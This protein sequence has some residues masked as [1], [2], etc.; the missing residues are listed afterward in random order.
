MKRSL[1]I[2]LGLA[3]LTGITF[4]QGT[5]NWGLLNSVAITVETN[6]SVYFGGGPSGGG[7]VGPIAAGAPN[8]YFELLYNTAFTGSQVAPPTTI[9]DLMNQWFDTGLGATN[10]ASIAGR[11]VPMA[12]NTAATVPWTG[13]IGTLGGTTNNIMLVGWSANLGTSWSQA[14]TTLSDWNFQGGSVVGYT[15]FGMSNT[16]YLVPNT[17]DPGA[18][19]FGTAPTFNGLPINSPNMQLYILPIP[20]PGMVGLIALGGLSLWWSRRFKSA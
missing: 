12:G 6:T 8:Y 13:G 20:E 19:V 15:F 9:S 2:L 10:A 16:G 1:L 4:G 7:V 14:S 18:V 5:V 17:G 11:I 3:A